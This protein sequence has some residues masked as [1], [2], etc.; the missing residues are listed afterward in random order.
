MPGLGLSKNRLKEMTPNSLSQPIPFRRTL[1]WKLVCVYV[2]VS[3]IGASLHFGG[4]SVLQRL[5]S[6][7]V[8]QSAL[9]PLAQEFAAELTP[10]TSPL[11]D[12]SKVERTIYDLQRL[13]PKTDTYLLDRTGK[14]VYSP[15]VESREKVPVEPIERFLATDGFPIRPIYGLDPLVTYERLNIPFSAAPIPLAGETGFVYVVLRGNVYRE[16][17]QV[18]AD[19]ALSALSILFCLFVF[20]FN[21]GLGITIF[22]L[23]TRRFSKL[24]SVV[25]RFA[26]GDLK[27]RAQ[28]DS[29]DEV[30]FHAQAFNAMAQRIEDSIESLKANDRLRRELIA[31]VSHDIRT[32]LTVIRSL[33][34][35]LHSGGVSVTE[36]ERSELL[37]RT[38]INCQSL[39]SLVDDLFELAKLNARTEELSLQAFNLNRFLV[40]LTRKVIPA[41]EEKD[42]AVVVNVPED[43][44]VRADERLLSRAVTNLLENAIRYSKLRGEVRVDAVPS[45]GDLVVIS[46]SDT[47]IGIPEDELPHVFDR[48]FRGSRAVAEEASGSGLGLAIAKRSIELHGHQI[49]VES[50]VEKGTTFRFT[51]STAEQSK[52]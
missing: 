19:A 49:S 24:T 12:R 26:D 7:K 27:V 41:A 20:V 47:G 3:F 5:F 6:D 36:E 1:F 9:W 28:E 10:F 51:L 21:I 38:L 42:L 16:F 46:V 22:R 25:T 13:N 15:Y 17:F 11:F 4:F 33:V 50:A 31:N 2:T 48:F 40:S 37:E 29:S 30:G 32:P 23:A 45:G 43:L 44:G 39:S 35:T 52:R 14:V 34:E 18:Q 8:E